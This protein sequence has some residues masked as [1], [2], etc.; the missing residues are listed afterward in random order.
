MQPDPLGYTL[1]L[2]QRTVVYPLGYPA[3]IF[4]N[5]PRVTEAAYES[6]G[7][8]DK[9]FDTSP[10]RIHVI[11]GEGALPASPPSFTAQ[12]HLL[13]ILCDRDNFAVCDLDSAFSFCRL[14]SATALDRPWM[15][16]H[17]LEAIA[18]VTLTHQHL[19]PVHAA[20]VARNGRGVLL[21][22]PSGTGKTVLS[23]SL[24]R[25]G[26]TFVS[27]DVSFLIRSSSNLEVLGKPH[28]FRFDAYARKL[29]PE[30]EGNLIV[31]DVKGQLL[32][33]RSA[34]D[35]KTATRCRVDHLVFLDR[36]A[37]GPARLDPCGAN[38]ALERLLR[39]TPRY[40]D[41]VNQEQRSSFELLLS[42]QVHTLHYSAWEQAVPLLPPPAR[43]PASPPNPPRSAPPNLRRC[44]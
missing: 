32:V 12:G 33:E 26:W 25:R 22:A 1:P 39:E 29:F 11:I 21:S 15:R 28:E 37:S 8:F 30:L 6:W 31:R 36:T 43:S 40:M 7:L 2:S 17:F 16:Y 23:Y 35:L 10:L 14:S 44:R 34:R 13:S 38:T 3:E 27:D 4:S 19:S 42:A 9:Q 18:Y 5:D 41:R 20:C 24:A